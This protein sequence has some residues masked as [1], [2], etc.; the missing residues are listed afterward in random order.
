M[1]LPAVQH[2]PHRCT[3]FAR[4]VGRDD[5]FIACTKLRAKAAAH[6]LRNHADLALRQLEDFG[7]LIAHTRRALRGRIHR[8]LIGLPVGN[9]RHA[10]P[11]PSASAPG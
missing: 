10:S 7:K 5:T 3:R 4:Q 11:V 9:K 8:Q 6:E 1:L 2:Q